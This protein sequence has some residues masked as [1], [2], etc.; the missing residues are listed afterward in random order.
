MRHVPEVTLLLFLAA[1]GQSSSQPSGAP[2]ERLALDR[3]EASPGI[4]QSPDTEDAFW[5]ELP[6]GKALSFGKAGDTPLLTISCEVPSAA[7]PAMR[8]VRHVAADP[9]ARALMAVIGNGRVLRAKADATR[10]TGQWRWE[11]LV[12]A[13]DPHLDVLDGTRAIEVT[14]PGG[15]TF[16]APASPELARLHAACLALLTPPEEPDAPDA[17]THRERAAG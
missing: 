16:E 8:L 12:P 4:S 6:S 2:V 14:L 9:G 10:H 7:Q 15:G 13:A 3:V 11:A 5:Q 17:A 1:C